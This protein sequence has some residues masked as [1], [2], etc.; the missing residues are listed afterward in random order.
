[1]K[2]SVFL[3]MLSLFTHAYTL[4]IYTDEAGGAKAQEVIRE[5]QNTYP[6]NVLD[7]EYRVIPQ[8]TADLDCGFRSDIARLPTC[9]SGKQRRHARRNDIDQP[10]II[11]DHDTYGGSGGGI[12]VMTT[13][14]PPSTMVHEYL[15][16][17]GL[18]DEYEYDA[19]EADR[20]CRG[21]DSRPNS[22]I[23]APNSSYASD[24]EARNEHDRDI[25]WYGDIAATTPITNGGSSARRLGTGSVG[26]VLAPVNRTTSPTTI[27]SP[28]GLYR[29]TACD[30]ASRRYHLWHPGQERNIMERLDAGLG[31]ANEIAVR[32]ILLERGAQFKPEFDPTASPQIATAPE[33]VSEDY[34]ENAI[35]AIDYIK[36]LGDKLNK[37]GSGA[38]KN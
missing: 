17:L 33:N 31:R 4:G 8:S 16:T 15:H 26:N 10:L 29:G 12:P 13:N 24:G 37:G 27:S 30:N 38:T 5:L 14:T 21:M 7:I 19:S 2:I 34:K 25:P 1:M 18:C 35:N 20:Y 28:I 36:N 11:M 3:L 23:I 22:A 6:F 9:N 32:R